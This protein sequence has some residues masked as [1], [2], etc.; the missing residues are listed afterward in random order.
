M[1]NPYLPVVQRIF[2]NWTALQLAVEHHMAGAKSQE[3]CNF[4]HNY[5]IVVSSIKILQCAIE[6]V[7][8]IANY[9]STN[10]SSL[11]LQ[12]V[13]EEVLDEEFDTICEDDSPK[14]CWNFISW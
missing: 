2:S 4:V 9:C 13:I 14:G 6:F 8:Y 1:E 7:N 11:D 10:C 3:V 5:K 12:D